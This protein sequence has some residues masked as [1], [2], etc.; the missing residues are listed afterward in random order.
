MG[1][2]AQPSGQS[3]LRQTERLRTFDIVM[4]CHEAAQFLLRSASEYEIT[5][6]TLEDC[7][8]C[9][10]FCELWAS[11]YDALSKDYQE[12]VDAKVQSGQIIRPTPVGWGR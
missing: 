5:F 12:L 1:H 6:C 7:L 4:T 10:E 9:E 8:I 11:V 3:M 2:N